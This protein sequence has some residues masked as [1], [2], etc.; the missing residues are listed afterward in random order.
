MN[1]SSELAI[2]GGSPIITPSHSFLPYNTIGHEEK[3]AVNDVLKS[4]NLSG[5]VAS[6]GKQ[7]FGGPQVQLFENDLRTFFNVKHAITVNSWTSGLIVML[8][9][10]GLEPG[11]EVITT[12]WT[13]CATAT[14]ILHWNAIP[15]FA[16]INSKTFLLDLDL[17]ESLIS[18]RTKAILAVDIFGQSC[19]MDKLKYLQDKYNVFIVS[20]SAQAPYAQQNQRFAGTLGDCGGFSFNYHKHIHTGEGGAIVTNNSEI[21]LRCQL[22][23]NHAEAAV[24]SMN[25]HN[26]SNMIGYNFRL[27]EMESAI[28][29]QQLKKLPSL[30]KNRQLIASRLIDGLRNL[31]GLILP[32]LLDSNTHVFYILPLSLEL[33]MLS[34][35]RSDLVE[36]LRF[37][38]VPG[39]EEGYCNIHLLPLF[40]QR[41]A[42]GSKGFPWSSPDIC[43]HV[44]NYEKGLCPVA[45][46]LHDSSF[47]MI[48]LCLYSF[49]DYDVDLIIEAF[50]KVWSN[51]T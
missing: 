11:D 32:E 18:T 25:I 2:N 49:T 44:P 51:L 1:N 36:A 16:D 28:G 47:F 30:V 22:I 42:Y 50:H 39:L 46:Y 21:A 5:F 40:Q 35:T 24:E 33:S 9:A 14:A 10:L 8:G 43:S 3:C 27:G 23:R 48:E 26:L 38:G 37:E 17:V 19:D 31:K 4:G 13:M 41:I 15:I 45:E 6:S 34:C 20:D 12:P 29:I 7:F